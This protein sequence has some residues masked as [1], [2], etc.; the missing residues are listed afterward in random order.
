MTG[1]VDH[2][3]GFLWPALVLAAA[4]T[5]MVTGCAPYGG[6]YAG[7]GLDYYEPYGG[8]YGGWGPDYAV[9]PYG[10]GGHFAGRGFG[11]PHA[12]RASAGRGIPSL[13][14]GGHFGGGAG[15]MGGGFGGGR[16]GGGHGHGR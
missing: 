16:G 10:R 12:F 2:R 3:S 5:L 14:R 7:P 4:V 15:R 11:G 13:P 1:H 6:G 9:G 8:V